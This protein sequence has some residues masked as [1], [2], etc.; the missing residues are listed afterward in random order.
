MLYT[1][2]LKYSRSYSSINTMPAGIEE[3]EQLIKENKL[4]QTKINT[5]VSKIVSNINILK[6]A[7]NNIKSKSGVNT[8][9]S[10]KETLDGL[11]ENWFINIQKEINTGGFKFKPSRRID[12]PKTNGKIRTLGI[13][14]PRDKIIQEAM[15][16]VLEAIYEP[17]F[18]ECSHGFRPG[19]G[20]HTAINYL[21][22]K[23]GERKWF[24][25]GDISKCFDTFDQKLLVNFLLK[26]IKDQVFMD[27][28]HKALKAGYIDFNNIF[29]NTEIG[30]PQGSII[31]PILCNIYL[32][33]FDEWVMN[34]IKSFDKGTRRKA[35]PEHHK[36][37]RKLKGTELAKANKELRKKKIPVT[38]P[39]DKTYKRLSY[40]RYA[41]DFLIGVI[42][43]YQDCTKIK[44]DINEFLKTN[45]NLNLNLEKT[46]ITNA[47]K[48]R[49]KFLGFEIHI[50]PINKRVILVRD[51]KEGVPIKVQQTS[52]PQISAPVSKI[53]EKLKERNYCRGNNNN[54]TR[55]GRLIH[56]TNSQ[57]VN[58]FRVLWLGIA[59]YYSICSNF[60]ALNQ[61]Y[62]ILLYSC[63][64]TLASKL[65][66]KTKRKVLK[67]FGKN[68]K[69]KN[70]KGKILAYF[71]SWEKPELNRKTW[72][73]TI[74]P[75]NLIDKL[76]KFTYRTIDQ[77]N[78]PCKLCGAIENI[79]M[80]H[81]KHLRKNKNK[82][83]LTQTMINI[84]R[85]Q[86]PLCKNC[87]I[88]IH[89]GLYD[90]PKLG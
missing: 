75:V 61:V 88:K 46:S 21:K 22:M 11:T 23:N 45:L 9:G 24:I 13:P 8:P 10:D 83:Y 81:I 68:I 66:L 53:V 90:G 25:E 37:V 89:K 32:H 5:N 49:A 15:K 87:H 84:N 79:E 56:S 43:S 40:V 51:N 69:I 2:L 70:E 58:H 64:L 20:C 14:S 39:N 3:L 38:Q 31:S 1:N 41:D 67:K 52:R 62:Y 57:I 28:I 73:E 19:K 77:F 12:I 47:S 72:M 71:P 29:H 4:D 59:N 80:H 35:N 18:L 86:V 78:E 7:Y 34:Y 42:G 54:P 74:S 30:T 85:K 65:R 63:V 82:D 33:K 44:I 55:V 26:R 6:L 60:A 17:T 48:N 36:I 27:L 50:T 76:S 16:L